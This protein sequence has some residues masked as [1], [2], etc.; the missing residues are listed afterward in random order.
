[1]QDHHKLLRSREAEIQVHKVAV[2]Q[3]QTAPL[4]NYVQLVEKGPVDR[5]EMLALKWDSRLICGIL[6]HHAQLS[7]R[8]SSL[9]LSR[10]VCGSIFL[11]L[12]PRALRFSTLLIR[13]PFPSANLFM[14]DL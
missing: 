1:M 13:L 4:I 12:A 6:Q 9:A 7:S 14:A 2:L 8:T 10:R 5:V 3:F 11:V